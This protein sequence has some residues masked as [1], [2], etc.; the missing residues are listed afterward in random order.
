MRPCILRKHLPFA[1]L[2]RV[3]PPRGK[4][5]ER[6]IVPPYVVQTR[7]VLHRRIVARRDE[8]SLTFEE[9]QP[10]RARHLALL[11]ELVVLCD[12]TRVLGIRLHRLSVRGH[13]TLC[14]TPHVPERDAEIAPRR[15]ERRICLDGGLPHRKRIF[16]PFAVV[17]KI[18]ETVRDVTRPVAPFPKVAQYPI[19]PQSRRE[20]PIRLFLLFAPPV[21][22]SPRDRRQ[23]LQHILHHQVAFARSAHTLL[24]I[25]LQQLLRLATL[26]HLNQ[27]I[28]R[29]KGHVGTGKRQVLFLT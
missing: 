1:A 4:H 11:A 28:R 19:V 6:V 29:V 2:P 5:L 23:P 15:R 16:V 8:R 21:G 26:P 13:R 25:P 24:Q 12:E 14:V 7:H 18:P 27:I 20:K 9:L 3:E 22:L 17:E 10:H